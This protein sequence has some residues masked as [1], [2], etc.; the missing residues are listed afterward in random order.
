MRG[1]MGIVVGFIV[2]FTGNDD[3]KRSPVAKKG[4]GEDD[5]LST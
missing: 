2:E 1:G 4:L 5:V 3:E